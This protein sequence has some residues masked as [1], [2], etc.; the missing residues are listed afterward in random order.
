MVA[1]LLLRESGIEQ[2]RKVDFLFTLA[3]IVFLLQ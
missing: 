1:D 2:E 3:E